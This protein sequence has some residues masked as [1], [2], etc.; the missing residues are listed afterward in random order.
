[1]QKNERAILFYKEL[2]SNL[3][4]EGNEW[5]IWSGSFN[6]KVRNAIISAS[7]EE[8]AY[9]KYVFNYWQIQNNLKNVSIL[10]FMKHSDL[11]KQAMDIRKEIFNEG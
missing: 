10:E 7:K 9:L 5:E 4:L 3:P 6:K 2:T 8:A 1:V 11:S